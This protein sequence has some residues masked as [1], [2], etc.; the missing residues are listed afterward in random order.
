MHAYKIETEEEFQTQR[1][2]MVRKAELCAYVERHWLGKLSRNMNLTEAEEV[3]SILKT[4]F[5]RGLKTDEGIG[6]AIRFSQLI[7]NEAYRIYKSDSRR[8]KQ[9]TE[10]KCEHCGEPM[11][12]LGDGF[13]CENDF[14]DMFDVGVNKESVQNRPQHISLD[15]QLEQGG[16][17]TVVSLGLYT[18]ADEELKGEFGDERLVELL[19]HHSVTDRD[20]EI[21]SAYLAEDDPTAVVV[22][23]KLG[24]SSRMVDRTIE[25][26]KELATNGHLKRRRRAVVRHI[27]KPVAQ[28]EE[29]VA[30]EPQVDEVAEVPVQVTAAEQTEAREEDLVETTTPIRVPLLHPKGQQL[31]TLW[32]HKETRHR[33]RRKGNTSRRRRDPGRARLPAPTRIRTKGEGRCRSSGQLQ[34]SGG[35]CWFI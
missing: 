5:M 34:R 12:R 22:A 26:L 24:I 20:R 31:A 2:G 1:V 28:V 29:P 19:K 13:V 21:I 16:D 30:A 3:V 23:A 33:E 14:C 15:E 7:F 18:E 32:Q 25:T 35:R 6:G 8:V 17:D 11:A 9:V 10:A 4:I 27:A